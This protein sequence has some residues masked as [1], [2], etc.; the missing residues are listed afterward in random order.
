MKLGSQLFP[1]LHLGVYQLNTK[2]NKFSTSSSFI[3]VRRSWD[4]KCRRASYVQE[5]SS[6]RRSSWEI[7]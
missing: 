4:R 5:A 1:S 7:N 2:T 3:L 6:T